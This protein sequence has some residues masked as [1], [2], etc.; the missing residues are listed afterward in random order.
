[1]EDESS[2]DL[3]DMF[4]AWTAQTELLI[5]F[6]I[7]GLGALGLTFS[8]MS[9]MNLYGAV[10]TVMA[11]AG[12]DSNRRSSICWPSSLPGL[13][14]SPALSGVAHRSSSQPISMRLVAGW[15]R[16]DRDARPPLLLLCRANIPR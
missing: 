11:L 4:I 1:M 16:N 13:S 7:F 3:G 10:K 6:A 14:V 15:G 5:L 9:F 12:A 8:L 2:N